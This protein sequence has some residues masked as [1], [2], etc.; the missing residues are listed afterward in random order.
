MKASHNIEMLVLVASQ[1]GELCNEIV[2][3]GGCITGLLITDKAAPDV[4]FTVDVDCVINIISL[5]DYH[6]LEK[7][8]RAKE[9]RQTLLDDHPICRWEYHGILLDVMPIDKKILGF[10]N[11]W[12][13]EA[14]D[15]SVQKTI[16]KSL[17][18]HLIT[19]TYFLATKFEAFKDRGKNDFIS[20]HDLED[21]IAVIDGRPEIIK[22]VASVPVKL[23]KYLSAE[24]LSLMNNANFI[25]A[26][27]GHL[28]YSD[29]CLNRSVIVKERI[30]A[31]I[32]LG[33]NL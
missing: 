31:I 14:L 9:F 15:N 26:L 5:S 18:I 27:P 23:K 4:R 32:D 29:E 13:K 33:D 25:N 8:L 3:V 7:K 1:L 22:D 19:A 17:K 28:N 30:R 12:Y 24:F 20:S 21:I 2:F 6:K 16:K 10:S 11:R